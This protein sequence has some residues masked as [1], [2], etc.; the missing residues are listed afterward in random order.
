[1]ESGIDPD[2][3]ELLGFA[4]ELTHYVKASSPWRSGLFGSNGENL[5]G[6]GLR[7]I[8]FDAMVVVSGLFVPCSYSMFSKWWI[9][10]PRCICAASWIRRD[11]D[12]HVYPTGELCWVYPPY[13]REV[14]EGVGSRL[15]RPV[16]RQTA[17]YWFAEQSSELISRHLLADR[18]S[19][20]KWPNEWSAWPHGEAARRKYEEMKLRGEV[21]VDIER[22]VAAKV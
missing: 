7:M 22:L 9:I 5:H 3:E 6:T 4:W 2:L 11:P 8:S 19:L 21:Q 13:W 18:L 17:A 15:N 14:L 1:M 12:W 16:A 10:P 20:N